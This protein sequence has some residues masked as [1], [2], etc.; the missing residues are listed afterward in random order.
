MARRTLVDIDS[1]IIQAVI[2]IGGREGIK[3]VTSKNVAN[4]CNISHFTCFEHF[5]T[6]QGMLDAAANHIQKKYLNQIYILFQQNIKPEEIWDTLL[7]LFIKDSNE[8][9]YYYNYHKETE[10]E[11]SLNNK[12]TVLL[13]DFSKF[14][15]KDSNAQ[16]D[17]EYIL[18]WDHVVEMAFYYAEKIIKNLIPNT[19]EYRNYIRK[20]VFNGVNH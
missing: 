10:C 5:G 2:E 3:K 6:R 14:I 13:L 16:N 17:L 18:L 8:S 4:L 20:I 15:F 9:M 7:D 19:K 11:L 12:R 1:K